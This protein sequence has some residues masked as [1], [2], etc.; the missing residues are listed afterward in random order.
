MAKIVGIDP[1]LAATG[2]GIVAGS[3]RRIRD[4]AYGSI[5]TSKDFDIAS[6]LDRIYSEVL[7][8]LRKERPAL[9]VIEDVFSLREQPR[10]GI[11]L[12]KVVGVVLLAAKRSGTPFLE[13]S[14]REAKKVLTGN[15]NAD[16]AQLERSVRDRLDAPAPIRPDH[17]SD[18]LALALIG[19][20]RFC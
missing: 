15:G 11:M 9:V 3:A 13:I 7:N 1:G 5:R 20:Y 2:V 18:A 12:G 8:V 10:S 17:A 16:K 4:F 14:T 19:L 6:R